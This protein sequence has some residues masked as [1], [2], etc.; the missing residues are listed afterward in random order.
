[1]TDQI[2]PTR[3]GKRNSCRRPSAKTEPKHR[4]RSP[5]TLH[6]WLRWWVQVAAEIIVPKPGRKMLSANIIRCQGFLTMQMREP[7]QI[8]HYSS[9]QTSCSCSSSRS[10]KVTQQRLTHWNVFGNRGKKMADGTGR[11]DGNESE[12]GM[13]EETKTGLN[14]WTINSH[15]VCLCPP[16]A[17]TVWESAI[18]QP[19]SCIISVGWGGRIIPYI[20]VDIN[21]F[22]KRVV[23]FKSIIWSLQAFHYPFNLPALCVFRVGRYR[24]WGLFS[25]HIV[26]V[27]DSKVLFRLLVSVSHL[28]CYLHSAILFGPPPS[29]RQLLQ[30]CSS[31]ARRDQEGSNG[32]SLRTSSWFP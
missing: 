1:M 21:H 10:L 32:P 27:V 26:H 16:H 29:V 4:T 23:V 28:N 2:H 3:I 24:T 17:T 30:R 15:T 11:R 22:F 7:S 25:A 20:H 6:V 19:L 5:Y 13:K 31:R 18:A 14:E 8:V 9:S 12:N